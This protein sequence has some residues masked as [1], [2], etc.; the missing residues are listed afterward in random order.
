MIHDIITTV[1]IMATVITT[2]ILTIKAVKPTEHR[3]PLKHKKSPP[4][5]LKTTKLAPTVLMDDDYYIAKEKT[6]I[7]QRKMREADGETKQI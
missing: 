3:T 4:K 5:S 6:Q 1:V 7:N 2:G